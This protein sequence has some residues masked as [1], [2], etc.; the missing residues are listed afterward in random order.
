MQRIVRAVFA[1]ERIGYQRMKHELEEVLDF[2]SAIT[3][4]RKGHLP[5]DVIT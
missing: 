2:Q 1:V 5:Q 3:V 4:R